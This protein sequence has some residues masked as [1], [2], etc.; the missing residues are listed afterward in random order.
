LTEIGNEGRTLIARG[1]E[2]EARRQGMTF[3]ALLERGFLSQAECAEFQKA[4]S[5]PSFSYT[6]PT[7][8]AAWGKRA[9]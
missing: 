5:D 3:Q 1:G 7:V 6:T 2:P 8:F 4:Y 9:S